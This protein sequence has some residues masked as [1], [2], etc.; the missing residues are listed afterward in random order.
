VCSSCSLDDDDDEDDDEEG[1]KEKSD[2]ESEGKE[3]DDAVD[4]DDFSDVG[5]EVEDEEA[6]DEEA[7]D[8]EAED[9]EA[10]GKEGSSDKEKVEAKEDKETADEAKEETKEVPEE[11]EA[12]VMIQKAGSK[13][14]NTGEARAESKASTGARKDS[15]AR[16]ASVASMEQYEF[17]LGMAWAGGKIEK[18]EQERL[19]GARKKY[20]VSYEQHL[21]CVAKM[22]GEGNVDVQRAQPDE[23]VQESNADMAA[24]LLAAGDS[25]AMARSA[26]VVPVDPLDPIDEKL[27][28]KCRELFDQMDVNKDGVLTITD[29]KIYYAAQNPKMNVESEKAAKMFDGQFKSI[30][31][32]N[33]DGRIVFEDFAKKQVPV[34]RV[35]LLQRRKEKAVSEKEKAAGAGLQSVMSVP[36]TQLISGDIELLDFSQPDTK[37]GLGGALLFADYWRRFPGALHTLD[38]RGNN[39]S[40]GDEAAKVLC[41][42]VAVEASGLR[43]LN[44]IHIEGVEEVRLLGRESKGVGLM[45]YE[46]IFMAHRMRYNSAIT[47]VALPNCKLSHLCKWELSIREIAA[48][49]TPPLP[50]KKKEEPKTKKGRERAAKQA[51]AEAARAKNRPSE[52]LR[53]LMPNLTSLDLRGNK[54]KQRG[55]RAI[56]SMLETNTTLTELQLSKNDLSN[57]DKMALGRALLR[58]PK[59]S[60][61]YF[62]CEKWEIQAGDKNVDLAG[63]GLGPDDALL[64]AGILQANDT[65]TRLNLVDNSDPGLGAEGCRM[66]ARVLEEKNNTLEALGIDKGR[67]KVAQIKK[68]R[69]TGLIL[70]GCELSMGA[71]IVLSK[72]VNFAGR[73][74]SLNLSENLIGPVFP[75]FSP[76]GILAIANAI[77]TAD[78]DFEGGCTIGTLNL[79]KNNLVGIDDKGGGRYT[80]NGLHFLCEV[81]KKNTSI[82]NFDI[83]SNQIP[84]DAGHMIGELMLQ[85]VVITTM[86]LKD[87]PFAG[88]AN[89][90]ANGLQYNRGMT[91]CDMRA[92]DLDHVGAALLG[93]AMLKN[94]Q[95][96]FM[97]LSYPWERKLEEIEEE[98]DAEA[99]AAALLASSS[100]LQ[101]E[102]KLEA[103]KS[104]V[105]ACV[106][107]MDSCEDHEEVERRKIVQMLPLS[108]IRGLSNVFALDLKKLQLGPLDCIAIMAVLAKNL[109]VLY[110]DLS[111]NCFGGEDG[112]DDA[113]M[114]YIKDCLYTNHTVRSI[115]L[116]FNWLE[117]L[118]VSCFDDPVIRHRVIS[119]PIGKP[120]EDDD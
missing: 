78:H 16:R 32:A 68:D 82:R 56:A 1:S 101:A 79:A 54:V 110:V 8:E 41:E 71:A 63:V 91:C 11:R 50:P 27:R 70:Q 30:T 34:M 100:A 60:L 118:T 99:H 94:R 77:K 96:G 21:E 38:L 80:K 40:N 23:V 47:K 92:T 115:D 57:N 90:I 62:S 19:E 13:D 49:A 98:E 20:G 12:E 69:M 107:E 51:A 52:S 85:N 65:V 15:V 109:H 58:N 93:E 116:S 72:I 18:G 22:A 117:A 114:E 105:L 29:L 25:M 3:G 113:P 106:D 31:G 83:S 74:V 55:S 10:S 6:E 33:H 73:L 2:A 53:P 17:L 28:V 66:L 26:P 75:D 42:A 84:A 5:D 111:D 95:L 81:L 14:G 61:K 7:E 97:A 67:I 103:D 59:S 86:K 120:A 87:N 64:L 108:L 9:E 102:H 44:G 76:D 36:V 89:A 48:A 39:I 112:M 37:L 46:A 88:G 104:M 35:Q 119:E 24:A 4:G 45:E 43:K